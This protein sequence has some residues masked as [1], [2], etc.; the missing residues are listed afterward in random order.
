MQGVIPTTSPFKSIMAP[1]GALWM[2]TV[3]SLNLASHSRLLASTSMVLRVAQ[4]LA[5]RARRQRIVFMSVMI[6]WI[7]QGIVVSFLAFFLGKD[8]EWGKK[9]QPHH[10]ALVKGFLKLVFYEARKI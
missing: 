5:N 10:D 3:R 2:V 4:P 7:G 8:E 6:F 9:G 1:L